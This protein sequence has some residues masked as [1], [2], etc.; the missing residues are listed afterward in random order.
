MGYWKGERRGT[1]KRGKGG[2]SG[3]GKEK[4]REGGKKG[5][6]ERGKESGR[7]GEE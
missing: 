4:G 2:R 5:R 1:G 6:R 7:E 3:I